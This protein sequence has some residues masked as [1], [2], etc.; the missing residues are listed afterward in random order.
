MGYNR[1]N[2]IIIRTWDEG[3]AQ[4]ARLKAAEMFKSVEGGIDPSPIVVSA[5]DDF[6]FFIPFHGSEN[7]CAAQD[8]FIR[9]LEEQRFTDGSRSF[10]WAAVLCGDD[11]ETSFVRNPEEWEIGR[12]GAELRIK[13]MGLA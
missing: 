4:A 1:R 13:G 8:A 5:I 9:W 3:R 7:G 11:G 6:T 2:T 12:R 10:S